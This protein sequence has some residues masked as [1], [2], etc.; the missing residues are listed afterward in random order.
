M[1]LCF[2]FVGV[3]CIVTINIGRDLMGK[4]L[5][6]GWAARVVASLGIICNLQ[7]TC[8]LVT[9][10]LRDLVLQLI[11]HQNPSHSHRQIAS[12]ATTCVAFCLAYLLR[13]NFASVCSLVGSLAISINSLVLP[14]FFYHSIYAGTITFSRKIA[15]IC[16]AVFALLCAV[17]GVVSNICSMSSTDPTI[18]SQFCSLVA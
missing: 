11:G 6:H 15:H 10:A 16:I 3:L 9:F 7:V 13:N 1:L 18:R 4:D 2:L 12:T 14:I 17:C 8:P 5:P